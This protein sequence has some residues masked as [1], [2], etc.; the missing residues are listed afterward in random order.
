[1]KLRRLGY[2]VWIEIQF[3]VFKMDQI[4]QSISCIGEQF[5]VAALPFH[6]FLM[7][8]GNEPS[9]PIADVFSPDRFVRVGSAASI[10]RLLEYFGHTWSP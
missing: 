7:P 2:P 9:K 5:F 10:F 3:G 1:M 8:N 6:R 4:V